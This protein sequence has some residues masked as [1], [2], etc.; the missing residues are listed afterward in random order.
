MIKYLKKLWKKF[1]G[2]TSKTLPENIGEEVVKHTPT[3]LPVI[4]LKPKPLHCGGHNRFK[5]S[6]PDCLI[7]VGVK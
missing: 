1:L 5:K 7:A 2:K 3:D 6:C 4:I